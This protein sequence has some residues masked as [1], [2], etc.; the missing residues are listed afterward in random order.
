MQCGCENSINTYWR[1]ILKL[2]STFQYLRILDLF[3]P[4]KWWSWILSTFRIL[5]IMDWFGFCKWWSRIS[6]DLSTFCRAFQILNWF[7]FYKC[8]QRILDWST[9]W[10]LW[11]LILGWWL[12]FYKF[13]QRY[14]SKGLPT[15][16]SLWFW[17]KSKPWWLRFDFNSFN[18]CYFRICKNNK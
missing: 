9:F 8:W 11:I 12:G 16:G 17:R 3:G 15:S 4:C 1:L 14:S 5:G 2:L 6:M 18:D 13:W 10:S 7:G